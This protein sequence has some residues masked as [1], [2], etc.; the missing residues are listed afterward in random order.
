MFRARNY[1]LSVAG[2]ECK[3]QTAGAR[4]MS[5]WHWLTVAFAAFIL[6]SAYREASAQKPK[7]AAI[8]PS[9]GTHAI[10]GR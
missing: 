2:A 4:E 10:A 3:V 1:K 8:V 6:S 9:P 5:T 7:C